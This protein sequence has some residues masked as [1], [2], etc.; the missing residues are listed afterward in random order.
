MLGAWEEV[1][2][3][4][5]MWPPVEPVLFC[6]RIVE[7]SKPPVSWVAAIDLYVTLWARPC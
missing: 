5:H 3:L 7:N 6:Q 1:L 2:E 4:V